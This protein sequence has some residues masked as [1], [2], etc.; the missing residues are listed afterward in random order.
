[1]IPTVVEDEEEEAEEESGE[2]CPPVVV[3]CSAGVGRTGALVLCEVALASLARAQP[4][5][6]LD[7]VRA[8][9]AQRPMC[10]QNAVRTH[11]PGLV[12]TVQAVRLYPPRPSSCS[13]C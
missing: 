13:L 3:H 2:L 12:L 1:M 10:I 9:R 5:Y 11:S 7:L 6:P 8:M 4:L